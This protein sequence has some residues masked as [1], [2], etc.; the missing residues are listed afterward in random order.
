MTPFQDLLQTLPATDGIEAIV[1]LN[2]E[3]EAMH[4]LENLPGTAGSLRVYHALVKRHGHIDRKAAREGLELF[5]EHTASARAHPGSHPN[6]D[7]LLAIAEQGAPGLRA[8]VVLK[9]ED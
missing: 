3:G 5:A 6:I 1:L 8:R 7:R 4:R 9:A 2:P